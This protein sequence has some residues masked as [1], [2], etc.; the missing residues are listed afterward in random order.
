MLLHKAIVQSFSLQDEDCIIYLFLWWWAYRNIFNF[1]F[2]FLL[3][4]TGLL[5]TS[6]VFWYTCVD[7]YPEEIT[8][9]VIVITQSTFQDHQI[10]SQ[11]HC[12]I[13]TL[14]HDVWDIHCSTASPTLARLLLVLPVNGC[15]MFS[16]L[17]FLS[18]SNTKYL[19]LFIH[20]M[21]LPPQIASLYLL[22]IFL[23]SGVYFFSFV[24]LYLFQ[25]SNSFPI[26]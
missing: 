9:S 6:V 11:S 24:I 7:I 13:Y 1:F 22:L 18:T 26:M 5:S 15:A 8:R 20:H 4:P 2:V 21:F 19:L 3:W 17:R 16:H 12:L 14:T 10:L 25:D 23:L